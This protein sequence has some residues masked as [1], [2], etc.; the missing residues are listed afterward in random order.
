MVAR[1][2][3]TV[4]PASMVKLPVVVSPT[5]RSPPTVQLGVWTDPGST[6]PVLET[7][8]A[9]AECGKLAAHEMKTAFSSHFACWRLRSTTAAP[10][11]W[12]RCAFGLLRQ[13]ARLS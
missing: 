6:S 2:L 10:P 11:E 3:E 1:S 8:W 7:N 5:V 13:A 4:A 9:L 12:M